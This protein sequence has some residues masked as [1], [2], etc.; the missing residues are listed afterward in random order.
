[1]NKIPVECNDYPG[2]ISNR[3]LMPMIIKAIFFLEQGLQK[4]NALVDKWTLGMPNQL[5]VL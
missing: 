2:F 3:I 1:M 4:K 5:G